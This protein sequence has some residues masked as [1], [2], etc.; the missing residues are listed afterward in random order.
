MSDIS[1]SNNQFKI[2][3]GNFYESR[4]SRTNREREED[5]VMTN[6]SISTN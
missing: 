5:M 2:K 3:I 4:D 1:N 6:F